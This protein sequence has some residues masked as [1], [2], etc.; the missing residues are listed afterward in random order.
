MRH[1]VGFV[2]LIAAAGVAR[3]ARAG[4]P[5]VNECFAANEKSIALRAVSKLREAR[6]QLAICQSQSCPAEVRSVCDRRLDDVNAAIPTL[7]F[8]VKDA[9]GNDVVDVRVD[10]DGQA[11]GDPV[12]GSAIALDPGEHTFLFRVSGAQVAKKT[13]VLKQTEKNRLER[14]VVGT[15]VAKMPGGAPAPTPSSGVDAS[16]APS[17]PAATT[18][19]SASS[20]S[21]HK[22]F[23]L[24][25][26]IVGLA[27]VGVGTGFGLSASSQWSQA[28]RDCGSGCPLNGRAQAE[29]TDAH[30]A[31]VASTISFSV[32][33]AGLLGASILWLTA[34]SHSE[35]SASTARLQIVPLFGRTDAECV[36]RGAF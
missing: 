17:L 12:N 29:G 33:A 36:L 14:I 35:I 16:D 18:A 1:T 15:A 31:A 13:F 27:G 6:G 9:A 28:Q 19:T 8:D 11:L 7:I 23:A 10:M 20:W 34:P 4:G 30:S 26:G 3:P 22:T 2:I 24:L 25:S 5:T 21:A 32:G